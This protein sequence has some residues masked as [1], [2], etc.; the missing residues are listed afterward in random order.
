ME[1]APC[2]E[3]FRLYACHDDLHETEDE[4]EDC[5]AALC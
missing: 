1:D 4:A 2:I 3:M 5:I